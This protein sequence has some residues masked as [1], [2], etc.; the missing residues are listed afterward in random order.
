MDQ[1]YR[2]AARVPCIQRLCRS[3]VLPVQT[4][5]HCLLATR[6]LIPISPTC[7]FNPF[8]ISLK[9]S[10]GSHIAVGVSFLLWVVR[11]LFDGQR[12]KEV[13]I[14]CDQLRNTPELRTRELPCAP[15]LSGRQS[16]AT[17]QSARG[18]QPPCSQQPQLTRNG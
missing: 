10:S 8:Q 13:E 17:E 4:S 11:Q 3:P 6:Q 18:H 15:F 5:A 9:F 12:N 1:L 2:T 16:C 14:A 7:H